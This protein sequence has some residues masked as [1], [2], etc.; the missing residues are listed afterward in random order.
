MIFDVKGLKSMTYNYADLIAKISQSSNYVKM[1]D[2]SNP[3]HIITSWVRTGDKQDFNAELIEEKGKRSITFSAQNALFTRLNNIEKLANS[4]EIDTQDVVVFI[5][6]KGKQK[7][8]KNVEY[9]AYY[10]QILEPQTLVELAK[11][12]AEAKKA[13]KTVTA[14]QRPVTDIII[15]LNKAG[16]T[17]EQISKEV[18]SEI[19]ALHGLIDK[20]SALLIVAKKHNVKID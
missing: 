16:V 2:D 17:N 9:C 20:E 19:T 7:N 12:E 11:K 13:E 4:I 5:E 10:V 3:R 8:N 1:N 6:Y 18:E 14:K 15:D